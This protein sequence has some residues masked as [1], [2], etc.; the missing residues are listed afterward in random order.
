[1]R[2]AD[3]LVIGPGAIGTYIGGH[4]ALAGQR[5][6]FWARP[7]SARQLQAHGLVLRTPT[8]T[9]SVPPSALQVVTTVEEVLRA[10]PYQAAFLTVKTYHLAGLLPQLRA[11]AAAWSVLVDLLNG[12]G[13]LTAL[14]TTLGPDAVLAGTVTTAVTRHAVGDI[15]IA[16]PRGV[17]LAQHP[18]TPRVA[19]ALRAAGLTVRLYADGPALKWSKLLTNLLGNATAA[20][21]DWPPARIYAHYGLFRLELAQIREAL[22]VM[23]AQN[24]PVVPLPGVPSRALAWGARYIPPRVLQPVLQYKVGRG[25]GDK[26]PSLHQD[27]Q[28]GRGATEIDALH[29]AVARA[30]RD[31]GL[32]APTNAL[33]ADLVRAVSRGALPADLYRHNPDALLARWRAAQKEA[34]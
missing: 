18:A 6:A 9:K 23:D 11:A 27:L 16:K 7:G 3:F 29:G 21:L 13:S 22:A 14:Q 33:L 8:A 4:L 5:V 17:G 10:G 2:S 19:A 31:L 25:R 32:A 24:L 12:V 34:A 1:M 28:A 20:L 15:T 26:M 30:A